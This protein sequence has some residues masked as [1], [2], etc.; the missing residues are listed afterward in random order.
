MSDEYEY[1]NKGNNYKDVDRNERNN[2]TYNTIPRRNQNEFN[3]KGMNR[4]DRGD[5]DR[6]RVLREREQRN[7]INN[8][9]RED[10]RERENRR[11][12]QRSYSN[13]NGNYMNTNYRYNSGQSED[14]YNRN[15]NYNNMDHRYGNNQQMNNKYEQ[16]TRR[17]LMN[18]T[19]NLS[20]NNKRGNNIDKSLLFYK[21]ISNLE[22][23][24]YNENNY[25]E[26]FRNN[27]GCNSRSPEYRSLSKSY[28][29]SSRSYS[30]G[31]KHK[32]DTKKSSKNDSEKNTSQNV[33]KM[34]QLR[35][36]ETG[37]PIHKV[38][39]KKRFNYLIVLPKNYLR[40]INEDFNWLMKEVN[41]QSLL[42]LFK[43]FSD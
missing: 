6:D 40:F 12:D 14:D 11:L 3:Y 13:D 43:T 32:V 26:R 36:I 42:C 2:L 25:N 18:N 4:D 17:S 5:R 27:E 39:L 7:R 19:E 33:D 16:G 22:F 35:K 1:N 31:S 30:G 23:N 29:A 34:D 15:K 37:E 41:T 9:N 38:V 20:K 24:N 8:N 21:I 10:N 28:S